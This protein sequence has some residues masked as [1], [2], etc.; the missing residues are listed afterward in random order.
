MRYNV[1]RVGGEAGK[2]VYKKPRRREQLMMATVAR[3]C[4]MQSEMKLVELE[5][6]S[7]KALV[8]A[9]LATELGHV[10]ENNASRGSKRCVDG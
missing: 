4:G 2:E 6:K 3:Q 5:L 9:V 10:S 8:T 1:P 7:L